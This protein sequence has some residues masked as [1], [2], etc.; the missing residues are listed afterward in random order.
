MVVGFEWDLVEGL[1]EEGVD[2]EVFVR[3]CR[4]WWTWVGCFAMEEEFGREELA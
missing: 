1:L 3:E 2:G 4:R